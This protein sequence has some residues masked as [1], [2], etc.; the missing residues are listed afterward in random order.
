VNVDVLIATNRPAEELRPVLQSYTQQDAT[1]FSILLITEKQAH[2]LHH[3]CK[4][5]QITNARVVQIPENTSNAAVARNKGIAEAE[6]DIVIF[7]DD[8]MVVSPDFITQHIRSHAAS[9]G[10]LV[11]G[12]RYQADGEGRFF[13]PFLEQVALDE[14]HEAK[15]YMAW[16]YWVTSNGSVA[17]QQLRDVGGFDPAF[18]WSGCEDTDLAYR[19]IRAGARPVANRQ[20]INFHLSIDHLQAKFERRIPNFQYF[21]Q[22]FPKDPYVQHFVR[23]TLKAVADQKV[24]EMFA[25]KSEA[26]FISL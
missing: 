7:S 8:D 10:A 1:D 6:G 11:R 25:M 17:L 23:A 18:P 4:E 13:L 20:A 26:P 21:A 9:P 5:L 12:I 3:L 22:K 14:W 19:L 24:D 15:A 2:G 16:A